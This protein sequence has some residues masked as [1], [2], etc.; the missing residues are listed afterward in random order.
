MAD[1][2]GPSA[3]GHRLPGVAAGRELT[4]F[5][6]SVGTWQAPKREGEFFEISGLSDIP[7]FID[8]C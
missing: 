4:S 3:A 6:G 7:L 8:Y 1:P 5:T 2:G